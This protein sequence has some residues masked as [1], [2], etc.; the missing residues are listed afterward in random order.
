M[1]E[2]QINPRGKPLPPPPRVEQSSGS[3]PVTTPAPVCSLRPC[4]RGGP[5]GEGEDIKRF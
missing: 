3:V 5:Q 1:D 2:I 4:P